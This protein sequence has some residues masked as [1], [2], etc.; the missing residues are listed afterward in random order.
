MAKR[1]AVGFVLL[2]ALLV[3]LALEP[4]SGT[5]ASVGAPDVVGDIVGA[6]HPK[7]LPKLTS[8]EDVVAVT[9]GFTLIL[10][11]LASTVEV[12]TL[13]PELRGDRRRLLL[14]ARARAR[15]GPPAPPVG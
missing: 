6:N 8:I 13:R 3:G 1:I 14:W 10:L 2:V 7:P 11:V 5:A 4:D 9:V 12:G 15:R